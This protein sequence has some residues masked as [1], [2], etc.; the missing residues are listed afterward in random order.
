[1]RTKG[2]KVKFEVF[3]PF[4]IAEAGKIPDEKAIVQ[5]LTQQPTGVSEE[6]Q[7]PAQGVGVY[8][9][10][11]KDAQGEV[12]PWYV[13]QTSRRSFQ[14]R[15]AQHGLTFRKILEASGRGDLQV[16]LLPMKVP[17][18]ERYRKPTKQPTNPLIGW[19]ENLLIGECFQ[20]N[21]GLLNKMSVRNYASIEVPGFLGERRPTLAAEVSFAKLLKLPA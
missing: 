5:A 21:N 14:H 16:F 13:G 12:T 18:S 8:V 1:V 11:V 7:V 10:V 20:L 6:R 2:K 17:G 15:L 4:T 19:L 3:G 9:L